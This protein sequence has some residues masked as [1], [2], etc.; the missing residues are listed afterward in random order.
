VVPPLRERGDDMLELAG[1]I[2][3]RLAPRVGI[4]RPG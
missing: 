4:E 2:L 3:A 1:H